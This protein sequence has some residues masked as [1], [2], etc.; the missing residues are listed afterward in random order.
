MV[1]TRRQTAARQAGRSQFLSFFSSNEQ[2]FSVQLSKII[3]QDILK[4]RWRRDRSQHVGHNMCERISDVFY[5]QCAARKGQSNSFPSAAYFRLSFLS[6]QLFLRLKNSFYDSCHVL[7]V[8][9]VNNKRKRE[10][11]RKKGRGLNFQQLGLSCSIMFTHIFVS[12]R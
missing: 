2:I 9:V 7:R 8:T 3:T 1:S 6:P 4:W 10:K 5:D 12:T 11:K